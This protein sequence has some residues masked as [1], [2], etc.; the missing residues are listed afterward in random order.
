MF[1]FDERAT[2]TRSGRVT[3]R[4]RVSSEREIGG[5]RVGRV[6]RLTATLSLLVALVGYVTS[7]LQPSST[8]LSIRS[9]EWLRDNGAAGIVNRIEYIYYTMTAPSKGGKPLKRLPGQ[10]GSVVATQKLALRHSKLAPEYVP[11]PIRP[12][13]HPALAGEG[14]WRATFHDPGAHLKY[15]PVLITSYRSDPA[16]PQMVAGVAWINTREVNIQLYPGRD[17]PSVNLPSRGPM[18]VPLDMRSKLVATFNSGFKLVDSGGGVVLNH[19]TYAPMK[20]G[21][22][23]FV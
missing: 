6:L 17:E 10:V 4:R 13:I 14:V 7:M 2:I 8:P 21:F 22:A 5:V 11:P 20:R 3:S 9:V 15:P 18:M 23:T 19:H 1:E 16:Y 12:L